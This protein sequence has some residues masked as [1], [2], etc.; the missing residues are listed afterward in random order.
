MPSPAKML[1]DGI[2][3]FRHLHTLAPFTYTLTCSCY[4]RLQFALLNLYAG[5]LNC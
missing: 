3:T 1:P 5:P 2:S 4:T